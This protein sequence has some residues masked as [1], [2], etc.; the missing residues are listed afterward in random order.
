[1]QTVHTFFSFQRS[2]EVEPGP[3]NLTPDLRRNR[4]NHSATSNGTK[5]NSITRMFGYL[6]DEFTTNLKGSSLLNG[7]FSNDSGINTEESWANSSSSNQNTS[8]TEQPSAIAMALISRG[9]M[10]ATPGIPC[11]VSTPLVPWIINSQS[12]KFVFWKDLEH[13]NFPNPASEF[14]PRNMQFSPHHPVQRSDPTS[15]GRRSDSLPRSSHLKT[16]CIYHGSLFYVYLQ[17]GASASSDSPCPTPQDSGSFSKQ[18]SFQNSNLNRR[19][20][21]HQSTSS[22]V[23]LSKHQKT[24]LLF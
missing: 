8:Q 20:P 24:P 12:R 4:N 7:Q 11:G 2:L 15:N 14:N 17:S 13:L 5:M 21:G 16:V 1:M 9:K 3:K 22:H 18:G 6:A 10:L 19:M 23:N